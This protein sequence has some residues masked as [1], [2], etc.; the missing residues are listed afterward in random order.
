MKKTHLIKNRIAL[1]RFLKQLKRNKRKTAKR[2]ELQKRYE[3]AKPSIK[4]EKSYQN[5][6]E[7]W[8]PINLSYLVSCEESDFHLLKIIKNIPENEGIFKVPKEFSIIDFP[9]ESFKFIQNVL[10]ALLLQKYEKVY[11]DYGECIRLDLGAQALFDIILKDVFTFYDRCKLYKATRPRVKEINGINI[12]NRDVHKLLFSV[13]SPVIFNN[14]SFHY[15]D[16]IPYK[17]CIHNNDTAGDQAKMREQKDIDT[18]KL[19]DYVLDCLKRLK[20]TL[21]AEKLDDLS[22]VIG[23]T[24]INAEEHST[25]KHRFSIG[26]FHE[27][28]E[29]DK[30]YGVFRLTILNFGKTIY[31]KFKDPQC[32]NKSVVQ[33][34]KNLSEQYTKSNFFSFKK[35][36]EETL[37]TL[38]ALQEG[39]TSIPEERY[40]KR[41]NGSIQFIESFFNIKGKMKE[42]D[43]LSLMSIL[44]GNTNILFD[45]TYNITSKQIDGDDY[46]FM[47]F[48]ESGNIDDKPDSKFV[49]FADNYFPGTI[50]SAKILF[51]EDDLTEEL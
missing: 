1:K 28:T 51:N 7:N 41:G 44:S 30:H 4:N 2:R 15:P 17:L 33:K 31:E 18:T 22:T 50:I 10:G 26:Y 35:F 27:I 5:A 37:W 45:G 8:L 21:T 13:G 40:K 16:I 14:K 19:V 3:K 11:I 23:E 39:V 9:K 6:L 24:L 25:T 42:N 49:K 12:V 20:R 36:E 29:G 34:M 43:D 38:Y 32:A 46:K 47:T 48:N